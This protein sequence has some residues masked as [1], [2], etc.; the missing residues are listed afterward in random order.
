MSFALMF[1]LD[2]IKVYDHEFKLLKKIFFRFSTTTGI[3]ATLQ[4]CIL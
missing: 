2:L 3:C 4:G 1:V